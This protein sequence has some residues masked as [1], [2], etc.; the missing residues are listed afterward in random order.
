MLWG[1]NQAIRSAVGLPYEILKVLQQHHSNLVPLG[2]VGGATGFGRSHRGHR[3]GPR[4]A[5]PT[6]V[7]PFHWAMTTRKGRR[8]CKLA[9]SAFAG[10]GHAPLQALGSNVLPQAEMASPRK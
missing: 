9:T 7:L 3:G 8:A 2:L 1:A 5:L 4:L 6:V 10:N